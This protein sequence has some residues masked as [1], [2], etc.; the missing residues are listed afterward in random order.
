MDAREAKCFDFQVSIGLDDDIYNGAF[1]AA[2]A[3]NNN[4]KAAAFMSTYISMK[5]AI[6]L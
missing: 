1:A 2:V 5:A 6:L 3:C 4:R